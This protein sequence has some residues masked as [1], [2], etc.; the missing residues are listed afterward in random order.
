M[1]TFYD[2]GKNPNKWFY[3]SNLNLIFDLIGHGLRF[4]HIEFDHNII[5]NDNRLIDIRK[6]VLLR[7]L[8]NVNFQE[9]PNIDFVKVVLFGINFPKLQHIFIE[10]PNEIRINDKIINR[11]R[12]WQFKWSDCPNDLLNYLLTGKTNEISP[13]FISQ[14]LINSS[15]NS[16]R[17]IKTTNLMNTHCDIFCSVS[18]CFNQSC[19]KTRFTDG[20]N[21]F[22]IYVCSKHIIG[23][24]IF[25]QTADKIFQKKFLP[26]DEVI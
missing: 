11:L 23:K 18:D 2:F 10:G 9:Y 13:K 20:S 15:F 4:K 12:C 21:I 26:D 22:W 5:L 14:T 6:K 25:K 16:G 3:D 8:L 24:F 19:G 1:K 7:L 17:S